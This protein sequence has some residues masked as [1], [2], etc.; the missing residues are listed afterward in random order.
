[1]QDPLNARIQSYNAAMPALIQ[2]RVQAGK[3]VALVDM[4]DAFIADKSYRSTL[5]YDRLHPNIAGFQKMADTW[6]TVIHDLIR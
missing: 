3:H 2:S 6:N 5:L 1:M 4:Y